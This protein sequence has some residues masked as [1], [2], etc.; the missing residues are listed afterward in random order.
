ME[1]RKG[2]KDEKMAGE[3]RVRNVRK[4]RIGQIERGENMARTRI[5]KNRTEE[6]KGEIV[7][8]EGK[9]ERTEQENLIGWEEGSE[10]RRH[11]KREGN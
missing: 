6:G 8:E 4:H 11:G 7:G 5:D 2:K 3:R 9:R 1:E 10:Q